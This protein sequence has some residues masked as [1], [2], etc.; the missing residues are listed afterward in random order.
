L[1]DLGC[2][3]IV[4]THMSGDMLE[5]LDDIEMTHAED[6]LILTL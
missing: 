5:R 2:R 3:R 1:P 6:G 4:L